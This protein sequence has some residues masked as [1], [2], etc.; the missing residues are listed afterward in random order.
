[1]C[2]YK[3]SYKYILSHMSLKSSI[4]DKQ[5]LLHHNSRK[6][7]KH[8]PKFPDGKSGHPLLCKTLL[9][10]DEPLFLYNQFG[11]WNEKFP[12]CPKM[13]Y[14]FGA[15]WKKIWKVELLTVWAVTFL[16]QPPGLANVKSGVQ[17]W[18]FRDWVYSNRKG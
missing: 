15:F 14:M 10:Q 7:H 8:I 2:I 13:C 4:V 12:Y 6:N 1:M 17:L 18:L 11:L 3:F 16:P 9:Q 5:L